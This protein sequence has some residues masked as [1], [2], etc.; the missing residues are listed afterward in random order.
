M[1]RQY[2]S[3]PHEGEGRGH[4]RERRELRA[5]RAALKELQHQVDDLNAWRAEHEASA[6]VAAATMGAVG[7]TH[8]KQ[9]TKVRPAGL[10]TRA[11]AAL[12]GLF[13]QGGRNE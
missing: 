9:S 2:L 3:N 6:K 13:R 1:A 7:A 5:L 4:G 11:A 10:W 8:R 12:R